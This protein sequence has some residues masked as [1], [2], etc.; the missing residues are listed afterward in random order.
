MMN[1]KALSPA[2]ISS[3]ELEVPLAKMVSIN[4]SSKE[5]FFEHFL[6]ISTKTRDLKK[7]F[8]IRNEI[9]KRFHKIDGKANQRVCNAILAALKMDLIEIRDPKISILSRLKDILVLFLGYRSYFFIHNLF[10]EKK[11]EDSKS[12]RHAEVKNILDKLKDIND[13]FGGLTCYF[14]NTDIDI[15]FKSRLSSNRAIKIFKR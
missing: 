11:N 6:D 1:K 13:H 4:F 15:G 2:W 5:D 12:F 9:E 7:D 10:V 14:P 3:K 8:K